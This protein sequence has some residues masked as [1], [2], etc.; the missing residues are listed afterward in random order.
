MAHLATDDM[1]AELQSVL[2]RVE[3]HERELAE[4]QEVLRRERGEVAAWTQILE[5]RGLKREEIEAATG[6]PVPEE[7]PEPVRP[8]K[9]SGVGSR[10]RHEDIILAVERVLRDRG[11]PMRIGEIVEDLKRRNVQLPGQGK[12]GNVIVH[13][14]RAQS[15]ERVDRGVYGLAEWQ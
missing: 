10:M 9:A 15:V 14:R 12:P 2:D 5:A 11:R 13:L 6:R 3:R 8:E 1:L 7:Q 4:A